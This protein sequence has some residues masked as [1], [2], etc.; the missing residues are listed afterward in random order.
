MYPGDGAGVVAA[1]RTQLG[2]PYRWG[3]TAA[4]AALDCS[5]LVVV[6]YRAVGVALPRTT[7]D[8]AR[9]GR[10]V[11]ADQLVPGDLVFFAGPGGVALG[12]VGI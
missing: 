1:A 2:V 5:G 12:H 11:T 9:V 10:A 7:Y 8:Q 6:A 3:G 4:G